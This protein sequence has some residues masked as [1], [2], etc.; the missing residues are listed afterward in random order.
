MTKRFADVG[1]RCFIESTVGS[2][3][4]IKFILPLKTAEKGGKR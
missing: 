3:T 2:G 1:G 4:S